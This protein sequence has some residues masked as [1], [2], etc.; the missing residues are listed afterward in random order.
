MVHTNATLRQLFLAN[1]RQAPLVLVLEDLHWLDPTSQR[2]LASLVESLAKTPIL[3]LTTCRPEALPAWAHRAPATVL[4]LTPLTPPQSQ[5]LLD[6]V[7]GQVPVSA[8]LRQRL[9]AQASG[10]PL[11]LEGLAR[12]V[13]TAGAHEAPGMLPASLTDAITA[14]LAQL[15]APAR[16]LLPRVA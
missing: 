13:T 11:L 14:R 3:V 12:Y 16:S 8:A 1:S 5:E 6:A 7:L 10:S 15:T 2:W 9:V 4:R